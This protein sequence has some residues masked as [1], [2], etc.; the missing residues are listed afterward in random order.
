MIA[1]VRFIEKAMAHP[2]DK[3]AMAAEMKPLRHLFNKSIVARQDLDVGTI[4]KPEHLALKKPG[5][6]LPE[7]RLPAVL[8]KKLKHALKADALLSDQDL[9]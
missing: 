8:G 2:V 4:L 6:G 1:G 5:T 3:N 9:A 7:E